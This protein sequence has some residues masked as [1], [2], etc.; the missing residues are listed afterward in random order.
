MITQIN[1]ISS[2]IYPRKWKPTESRKWSSTVLSFIKRDKTFISLKRQ[3]D[4]KLSKWKV[5]FQVKNPLLNR[6]KMKIPG[7]LLCSYPW[8]FPLNAILKVISVIMV[9]LSNAFQIVSLYFPILKMVMN[10][11]KK[12][13]NSD[14]NSIYYYTLKY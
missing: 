9:T 4:R 7:K 12:W 3:V 14:I 1:R 5:N 2:N 10:Q 8:N 11:R 6:L 13:Y